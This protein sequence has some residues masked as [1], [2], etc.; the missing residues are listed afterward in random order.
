M[1]MTAQEPTIESRLGIARGEAAALRAEVATITD[2]IRLALY[3][4]KPTDKLNAKRAE[5]QARIDELELLVSELERRLPA[6]HKAQLEAAVDAAAKR[7]EALSEIVTEK[8][9]LLEAAQA[10]LDTA[11]A[12]LDAAIRARDASGTFTAVENLRRHQER[13]PHLF[14]E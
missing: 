13:F 8:Q 11:A 14:V 3:A 4:S 6:E 9:R 1:T 5:V 2:D 10:A 7:R 12:E